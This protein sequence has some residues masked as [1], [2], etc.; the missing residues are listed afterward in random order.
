M[1]EGYPRNRV[2]IEGL[3]RAGVAVGE[4]HE[5]FWRGADDKMAGAK[6][7]PRLIRLAVR[8]A[9]TWIRLA[10]RYFRAGPHD[11][12]IVGYTGQIDVFLA[13]LLAFANGRPVVL[14][15]FL[16][17]SDTVVT[18]RGLVARNGVVARLLRFLDRTSCRLA[19]LVLLDTEAH[20]DLFRDLT[21]LSR[22]RFRRLFVGEDDVRFPP[23]PPASRASRDPLDVLWFG[24]YVPLQGAETIVTA[25]ELLAGTPVRIRMIGRGQQLETVRERAVAAGVDL[26][27]DWVS[28]DELARE[29]A[30]AH[31]CL[32]IFGA[33]G[34]ARRVI[35]CKVYD[36]LAVGRA[37]VTSDTPGARELLTDGRNALLVPPGDST[38]LA[39]AILRL[40]RDDGLRRRIARAGHKT[41][42]DRASP[43]PL[44]RE[45][46]AILGELVRDRPA[47]GDRAVEF[48]GLVDGR[49]DGESR[50]RRAPV[51]LESR[52][53]IGVAHQPS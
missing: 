32:G 17:L 43:T 34:K 40:A 7:G 3:R 44:G 5:E 42:A 31:V 16:S 27:P 45:L 51:R 30:R 29:I 24:T 53:E 26:F 21:G 36:A 33:S 6:G 10:V 49:G 23:A 4:V 20:I 47:S 37:V 9:A 25:A 46:R 12:V 39:E 1:G 52:D 41:F 50:G 11:A 22:N 48:E 13:R 35:P 8:Y 18:D 28:P 14:D 38:A 15:A 2:L 19:D